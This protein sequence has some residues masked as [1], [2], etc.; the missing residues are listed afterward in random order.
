MNTT[1]QFGKIDYYGNGRKTNLVTIELELKNKNG[2]KTF[3]ASGSIWN[4]LHSDIV[5]G[6]QCLDEISNYIHTPLFEKIHRL[7]KLYHLNDMHAGTPEQEKALNDAGLTGYASDYT[8]CC[9]Y[10]K[11][12]N[13]YE[14]MLNGKPYKFGCGWLTQPIPEQDLKEIENIITTL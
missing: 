2:V 13:L 8:K 9:D 12:I 1:I 11:S 14:V 6:G 5:C 10:L 7:W 4:D 3:S